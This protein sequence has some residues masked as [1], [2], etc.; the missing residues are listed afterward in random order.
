M[1]EDI[2]LRL[3]EAWALCAAIQ[4]VL[5][6]VAQRTRNAGIVD[7]GWALSFSAVV[8]TF[9]L[10]PLAPRGHTCTVFA[11]AFATSGNHGCFC[12]AGSA[13]ASSGT[14]RSIST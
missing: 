7:V 6:L 5:W 13:S 12:E 11:S 10:Q 2:A 8:L 4:A 14:I 9:A 1:I 3:A